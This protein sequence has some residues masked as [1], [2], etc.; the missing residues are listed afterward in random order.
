MEA[1]EPLNEEIPLTEMEMEDLALDALSRLGGLGRGV[2][3]S[4]VA[5]VCGLEKKWTKIWCKSLH[6]RDIAQI[7]KVDGRR[8][9]QLTEKGE[10]FLKDPVI[11]P[12]C[13]K[14][15]INS[16]GMKLHCKRIHDRVI[17]S[18]ANDPDMKKPP[19]DDPIELLDAV[20]ED[21]P[22]IAAEELQED[23]GPV[24]GMGDDE[25]VDLKD[26]VPAAVPNGADSHGLEELQDDDDE[27]D[28]MELLEEQL[29]TPLIIDP[30]PPNK[31]QD[32]KAR[33]L[34][35]RDD[36]EITTAPEREGMRVMAMLTHTGEDACDDIDALLDAL[37]YCEEACEGTGL[38]ICYRI[39]VEKTYGSSRRLGSCT[40][41]VRDGGRA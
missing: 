22:M 16:T 10:G 9:Y 26:P 37:A 20:P 28:E 14:R 3:S 21:P 27:V 39:E 13:G 41:T 18:P 33:V 12:E 1:H 6:T 32:L 4:K 23:V 35:E 15:F 31:I 17:D 19:A 5:E 34:V 36:W 2:T 24:D 8:Y 7:V 40:V 38:Q 25:P 11:C 30:A 29:R